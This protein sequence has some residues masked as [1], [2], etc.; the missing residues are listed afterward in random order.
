MT[1]IISI[2]NHKGGVGKTTTSANL[3]AGLARMGYKVL[4]VDMDSQ[5]NL[6]SSLMNED[7]VEVS[8]YDSMKGDAPLPVLNV[9][10][11]L[12]LIPS[13]LSL[14]RA[15]IDL[16]TRIAR[17]RILKN[18]LDEV[19]R[20]YDYILIDCPPSLGILT[21]NALTASTDLYL[22]LTGEALP[23][24]GL[25]MLDEVVGEIARTINPDLKVSGVIITR[26]NNRRLNKVVLDAI[27]DRYGDRLFSTMIRENI[28]LAESPLSH[29][30]IFD[31]E[32]NS[33]GARD[34]LSLAEEV[35]ER[36]K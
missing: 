11:N 6:T 3:G 33:N 18:L 5:Q 7:E 28:S 21:M 12:D 29:S 25:A 23:L 16:S 17:E 34:Y 26:Y 1:K 30:S 13:D 9:G 27:S 24:R 8:V 19:K 10:E 14:A 2:A 31:Y 15:E 32:P 36:N 20:N 4:L 35:V 22:P